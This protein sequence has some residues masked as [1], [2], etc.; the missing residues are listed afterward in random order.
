MPQA[1][2]L[3]GDEYAKEWLRDHEVD[4]DADT[5]PDSITKNNLEAVILV[6]GGMASGQPTVFLA[7]KIDGRMRVVETSLQLLETATSAMRSA[8]GVK[9]AP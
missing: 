5:Y 1:T 4:V 8:S 3:T 9:R 2:L 7:V 6:R